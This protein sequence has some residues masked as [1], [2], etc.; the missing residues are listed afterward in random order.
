MGSR[1]RAEELRDR[2]LGARW[3]DIQVMPVGAKQSKSRMKDD[4]RQDP[5][6]GQRR[7]RGYG[8]IGGLG[9]G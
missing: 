3:D 6:I 4:I 5:V 2:E 7:K 9:S 1:E 8:L